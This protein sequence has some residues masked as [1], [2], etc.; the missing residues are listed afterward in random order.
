MKNIKEIK[1]KVNGEK[2]EAALD[3][4][5]KKASSSFQIDGFRKGKAPKNVFLILFAKRREWNEDE[6]SF[7]GP[8]ELTLQA[9][10]PL[11]SICC[12]AQR[13]YFFNFD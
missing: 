11:A 7:Y 12:Y 2:W 3:K 8:S 9:V 13:K 6:K 5:Y 1:I 10:L 4:A